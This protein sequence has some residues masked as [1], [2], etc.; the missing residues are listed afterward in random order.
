MRAAIRL[1]R[2]ED[3]RGDGEARG[4][5]GRIEREREKGRKE[6]KGEKERRQEKERERERE[7]K[8][9]RPRDPTHP[10]AYC[11]NHTHIHRPKLATPQLVARG[12]PSI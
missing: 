4:K 2:G 9:E 6:G 8:N 10:G 1:Q 11:S 7:N 12:R 3:E 5:R